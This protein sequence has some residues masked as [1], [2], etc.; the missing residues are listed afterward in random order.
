MLVKLL[1]H[2]SPQTLFIL[3]HCLVIPYFTSC[4]SVWDTLVSSINSENL[5]KTEHFALKMCSRKW[6]SDYLSLLSTFN[7][8]SLST[9]CSISKS[10]LLYKIT[11]KLLYFLSGTY[12]NKFPPNY[13]SHYFHSFTFSIPFSCSSAPFCSLSVV[14]TSLSCEM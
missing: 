6:D 13:G 1:G 14:L 2:T 3:Y 11:N 10:C 7:L 4:F 12:I 8:P 5:E 9:C